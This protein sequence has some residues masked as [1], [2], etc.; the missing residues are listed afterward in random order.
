MF[1][2]SAFGEETKPFLC[3]PSCCSEKT[4]LSAYI[5]KCDWERYHEKH[6]YKKEY[7]AFLFLINEFEQISAV[8]ST[9][10]KLHKLSADYFHNRAFWF[11]FM[12]LLLVTA[13]VSILGFLG[14]GDYNDSMVFDGNITAT[15]SDSTQNESEFV[16]SGDNLPLTVGVLGV[17]STFLTSLGKHLNYQSKADMHSAAVATLKNLRDTLHLEG[18]QLMQEIRTIES[19]DPEVI[20]AK[21]RQLHVNFDTYRAKF[22]TMEKS[23]TE[24]VPN[25][26]QCAFDG[27]IQLCAL[28]PNPLGGMMFK[29]YSNKLFGEFQNRGFFPLCPCYPPTIDVESRFRF[30]IECEIRA[31]LENLGSYGSQR[32]ASA[33]AV[34]DGTGNAANAAAGEAGNDGKQAELGAPGEESAAFVPT[35]AVAG[36]TENDVSVLDSVV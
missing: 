5:Q 9:Y 33:E 22:E 8:F 13:A 4:P 30:E 19:T 15:A 29:R 6:K 36:D 14:T 17:V 16:F 24:P 12:P 23:C 10:Q 7:R 31:N 3:D 1:S 32:T 27:L 2:N 11:T 20:N 21:I 26:I 35:G 34:D 25:K 18:L 28:V